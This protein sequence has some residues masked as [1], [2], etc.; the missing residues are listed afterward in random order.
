MPSADLMSG[1]VLQVDFGLPASRDFVVMALDHQSAVL[2][3]QRHLSTKV[4]IMI[5]R[6]N[7][8]ITFFIARA[9]AEVVL[10]AARVPAALFGVD[11][12]VTFVL[13]L[14]EAH[15]VEDEELRLGAKISRVGQTSGGEIHLSLLGYVTRVAVVTLL[16]DGIDDVADHHQRR[17]LGERIQDVFG[18]VGNE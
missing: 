8:E 18:G 9:I 12:V 2:H 11:E 3:G 16:G 1:I 17:Y 15:V 14:I 6:R 10:D 5:G 4:L 13:V 7:R